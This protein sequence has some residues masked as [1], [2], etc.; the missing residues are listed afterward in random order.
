M[1][2]RNESVHK[3]MRMAKTP[4]KSMIL[5]RPYYKHEF[6]HIQAVWKK[7]IFLFGILKKLLKTGVKRCE[8]FTKQVFKI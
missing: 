4:Y 1:M 8:K 3:A 7:F 5:Q 6:D 2:G